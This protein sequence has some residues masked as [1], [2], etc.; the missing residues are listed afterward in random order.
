MSG[1][2]KNAYSQ[3]LTY[4]FLAEPPFPQ[5]FSNS[6]LIRHLAGGGSSSVPNNDHT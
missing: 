5:I 2:A 6:E 1:S 4:L 3:V